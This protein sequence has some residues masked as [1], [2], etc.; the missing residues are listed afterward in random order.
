[1]RFTNDVIQQVWKKGQ[2]VTG[3]SPNEW[4]KDECG[5][6]IG[7][8]FYGNRNSQYGW[9]IDHIISID[10][11]GSDALTNLRPL[12]WENNASKQ[13]GRLTCPITAQGK[14]NVRR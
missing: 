2:V 13:E 12:Q 11:G 10:S 9:E 6:W 14:I 3:N 7:F 5:A 1:M 8:R 4:R